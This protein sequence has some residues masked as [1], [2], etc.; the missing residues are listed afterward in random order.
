DAVPSPAPP[1]AVA[2]TP[3]PDRAPPG[4]RLDDRA[5]PVAYD[6][7]LEIDPA[8][9]TF[10]GHVAITIDVA[11]ATPV[12][13]LH[14]VELE[15]ARAALGGEPA[16]ILDGG[17]QLR[18]FALGHPVAAGRTTLTIDYTGKVSDL[19]RRSGKDEEGLFR[20][21]AAGA[22]Y[23][24][25]QAE[26]VFARKIVPC[27]DEPRW[28][29]RWKLTA[30]VPAGVRALGNGAVVDDREHAPRD[31]RREVR[32]AEVAKLPSYLFAVAVGPFD[33]VELGKLGRAGVA[34]RLA[35]ARGD[36]R[37]TQAAQREVPRVVDAI[38]RYLDAPLPL[39]KL[40]LVA[41]PQFFG[42][43]EN[44]GL[45]PYDQAI[46][47][48][49]HDLVLVTAHELAHQW[50]GNTVTPAWWDDLWLSE[51]LAS[52]LGERITR[53][54]GAAPPPV[55]AHHARA[56]AL[57]AD[58][59]PGA[60]AVI[61]PI[62]SSEE[63]EPSFD[64]IAY[65]KGSAVITMFER[66][67]NR[68]ARGEPL[69]E[70]ARDPFRAALTAYLAAH[71]GTSVT[72]R[73]LLEPLARAASPAVS[74]ALAAN[75]RHAGTPV[76]ELGVRCTGAPAITAAARDGVTVPVCVRFAA[77]PGAGRMCFLAGARADHALPAGAACPAWLVGN[78]GGTGYYRTA[79]RGRE[80]APATAQ[81]TPEERLVRGDDLALAVGHGELPL[82]DALAELTALAQT[83]DSY[84]QLA[85]LAIAQAIDPWI[86]DAARPAWAAWLAARFADRLTRAALEASGTQVDDA[87]R[88]ALLA[89]TRGALAP[90]VVAGLRATLDRGADPGFDPVLRFDLARDP[91]A[92][93]DRVLA[94][95]AADH[96]ELRADL[97][98]VLGA[99]PGKLA[100][101]VVDAVLDPRFAPA[102]V[103]PALAAMLARG[104]SR[105]A[106]WRAFHARGGELRRALAGELPTV[107]AATASLCDAGARAEVAAE[108]AADRLTER[109]RPA[110]ARAL[111][112]ALAAIDR[113]IARRAAV[114][115]VARALAGSTP[116]R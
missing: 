89:L 60:P 98:E 31:G 12:I 6:V 45:I 39:A 99:F 90:A 41:V 78:D 102:Q 56:E 53:A 43:M 65:A 100:P 47:V 79:W 103:W 40:D 2:A 108:F 46:L 106:A 115:D 37:R 20:E 29:P 107:I 23:V 11:A 27:F 58:D 74:D 95:A 77:G 16:T 9:A 30:I 113:C 93:L 75:L 92:V 7:T 22:W 76:V 66:F 8:R 28:K 91:S 88:T 42:A 38:E 25:S 84:Q 94:G 111:E 50:F 81:L 82:A 52:W 55:I 97:L 14:A 64:A 3:V 34:V 80:P 17:A 57:A 68:D 5:A 21:R 1:A 33:V 19:S 54:L 86:D 59:L 114:G 61:H 72:S 51:A 36:G 18:G 109:A 70:P 69:A 10:T 105:T 63:V 24:Y 4:P 32:F 104:E 85:A 83:R 71:A 49:G 87:V 26:S 48:G 96:G 101:R 112:R 67:V 73:A 116:R 62:A 110:S 13:W 15:L 44:P 35:V